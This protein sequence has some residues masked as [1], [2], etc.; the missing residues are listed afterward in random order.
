MRWEQIDLWTSPR[1]AEPV[2]LWL[3][4]VDP[5]AG[6]SNVSPLWGRKQWVLP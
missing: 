1:E 6:P 2:A 3:Q 4:Q 5:C